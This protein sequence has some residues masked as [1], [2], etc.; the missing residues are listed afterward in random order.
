M[1]GPPVAEA[2]STEELLALGW[3]PK[4]T[5]VVAQA[6]EVL[7]EDGYPMGFKSVDRMMRRMWADEARA[8]RRRVWDELRIIR[9]E[10]QLRDGHER[11]ASD[12][13]GELASDLA[14]YIKV[15]VKA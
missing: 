4:P 6:M 5:D 9:Q 11:I 7:A 2:T 13:V 14:D 8:E 1:T 15:R 10:G 12:P 3:K